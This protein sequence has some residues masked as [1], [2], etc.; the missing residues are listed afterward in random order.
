MTT[1]TE[2][3][4]LALELMAKFD[5]ALNASL[6]SPDPEKRVAAAG[7]ADEL[8]LEIDALLDPPN[9]EGA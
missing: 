4:E 7:L 1:T 8:A 5:A 6:Y 9:E 3:N 2:T